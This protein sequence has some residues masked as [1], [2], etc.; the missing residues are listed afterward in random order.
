MTEKQSDELSQIKTMNLFQKML[1]VMSELSYLKKT[2]SVGFGNNT[3]TALTHDHVAMSVQPLLVKYR[4]NAIPTELESTI[5]RY[6][7][8]TKKGESDRYETVKKVLIDFVNADKPD[9]RHQVVSSAH[10]FDS[11]DKSPGKAYSM[12]V[13]YAL[14]KTFMIASGDQEEDRVEASKVV[15]AE[16]QELETELKE[17]LKLNN[18]LNEKSIAYMN[19]L[20]I[21]GLKQKID[22]YKNQEQ[23]EGNK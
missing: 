3:Y 17:L 15:S 23:S 10:G 11:Q 1:G 5:E 18:K 9:E 4:L 2:A 21:D 16:R 7:V 14:L 8:T 22:Q 13:K 12:A 6:K 19:S 20:D